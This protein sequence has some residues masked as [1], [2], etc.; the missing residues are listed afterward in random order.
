[1][2]KYTGLY[3]ANTCP[4]VHLQP[5]QKS[6]IELF[7]Q[8]VKPFNDQCSHHIETSQLICRGNQLTGFYMMRTLVVKMLTNANYFYQKLHFRCLTGFSRRLYLP[9]WERNT[10]IQYFNS[11]FYIQRQ[12]FRGVL[13]IGLFLYSS[14]YSC[15]WIYWKHPFDRVTSRYLLRYPIQ[16]CL[17]MLDSA[18]FKIHPPS[19]SKKK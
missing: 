16:F 19:P 11:Y 15:L 12:L 3:L 4:L 17:R 1:M 5:S 14:I 7:M 18:I 10:G 6:V 13:N 9:I 8:I 2:T